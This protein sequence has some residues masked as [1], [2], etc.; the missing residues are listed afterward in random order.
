MVSAIVL[1]LAALVFL[2]L[3]L[4]SFLSVLSGPHL[5]AGSAGMPGTSAAMFTAISFGMTLLYFALTAWAV[6][7]VRGLLQMRPWARVSGMVISGCMAGFGFLLAVGMAGALSL[8]ASGGVPLPPTVDPRM[9]HKV[10]LLFAFLFLCVAALGIAGLVYFAGRATREA[11]ARAQGIP[12]SGLPGEGAT[13]VLRSAPNVPW[14]R[15]AS[16]L[17]NR[18]P[19]PLTDFTVARP[20]NRPAPPA[21]PAAA[22]DTL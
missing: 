21:G 2:L 8:V 19:D 11:F 12:P 6:T 14:Q 10:L 22:D 5:P 17:P 16:R 9:L 20:L 3:G 18:L 1:G 4:F 15:V 7:T 13:P